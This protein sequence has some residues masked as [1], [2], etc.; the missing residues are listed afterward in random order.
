MDTFVQPL[1]AACERTRGLGLID[2]VFGERGDGL[3]VL[4]LPLPAP[5][6]R[7]R[8]EN[9]A[10]GFDMLNTLT[11]SRGCTPHLR[12]N[13]RLRANLL[14]VLPEGSKITYHKRAHLLHQLTIR[15]LTRTSVFC[16]ARERDR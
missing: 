13:I 1:Q 5:P 16:A 6:L 9:P 8:F 3:R 4:I 7:T 10:S 14:V 11:P 12:G 15:K 2:R